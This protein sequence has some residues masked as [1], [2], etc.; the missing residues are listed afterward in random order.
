MIQMENNLTHSLLCEGEYILTNS[1][2]RGIWL[3][4]ASRKDAWYLFCLE[5]HM[6]HFWYMPLRSR[7]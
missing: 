7:S 3:S 6:H 2:K 5:S 4:L 1:C